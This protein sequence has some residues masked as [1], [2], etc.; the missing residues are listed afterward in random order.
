MGFLN[1]KNM[2]KIW[3]GNEIKKVGIILILTVNEVIALK[4]HAESEPETNKDILNLIDTISHIVE[5]YQSQEY[6]SV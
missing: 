3:F 1:R 2:I 5:V 6:K 4:Q